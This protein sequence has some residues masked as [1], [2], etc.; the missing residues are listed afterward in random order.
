MS[1][2]LENLAKEVKKGKRLDSKTR[3]DLR[4]TLSSEEETK[5]VGR[6]SLKRLRRACGL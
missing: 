4:K 6:R 2:D 1:K 3:R 5:G